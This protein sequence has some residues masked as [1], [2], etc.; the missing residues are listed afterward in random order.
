M[1]VPILFYI[2]IPKS[3]PD[4]Q[5]GCL[6]YHMNFLA[7]IRSMLEQQEKRAI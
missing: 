5:P 2:Q 7:I 4:P 6:R 1:K 3:I